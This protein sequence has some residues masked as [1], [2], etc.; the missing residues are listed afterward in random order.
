ME[1][2]E[3]HERYF[4]LRSLLDMMKKAASN[5][6]VLNCNGT[7]LEFSTITG[8]LLGLQFAHGTSWSNLM[9]YRYVTYR[10]ASKKGMVCNDTDTCPNPIA[11]AW[12]PT[13]LNLHVNPFKFCSVEVEVG[14]NATLHEYYGAPSKAIIKYD[15]E[16]LLPKMNVSVIWNNKTTTRL[17]EATTIFHRPKVRIG[18]RWEMN[19]LGE[20][21]AMSNVTEGG[22]QYQHAVWSGI[23]YVSTEGK[24]LLIQTLDAGI[25]CPVLN[26]KADPTLTPDVSLQ[27]A[28][29]KYDIP[30]AFDP[31]LQQQLSDSVIAGAGIRLHANLFDI[32]GFPQW[33]PFGVGDQFQ[34]EDANE[35]F[36]FV[37]EEV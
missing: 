10:D 28:C 24:G 15:V 26:E 23:R 6:T 36:R 11:G 17:Q 2:F 37:I 34:E 16:P 18:F 27:K 4:Y 33:Y 35:Q 1:N 14:F 22:E 8:S 9:D 7:V 32:S 3:K 31:E 30:S 19:K 21:V 5:T 13:L 29:D 12:E 20:W 25:A